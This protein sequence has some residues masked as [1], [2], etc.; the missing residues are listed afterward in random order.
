MRAH[1]EELRE[2]VNRNQ[3]I[4]FENG[5]IYQGQVGNDGLPHGK[6]TLKYGSGIYQGEFKNGSM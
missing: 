4:T 3:I 2:G 1:E 6:G 5:N